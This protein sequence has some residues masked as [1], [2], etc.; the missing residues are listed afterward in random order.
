[1]EAALRITISKE[2][3]LVIIIIITMRGGGSIGVARIEG[4]SNRKQFVCCKCS[5]GSDL[6]NLNGYLNKHQ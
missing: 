5:E 2:E 6:R 3:G 4:I 1:M